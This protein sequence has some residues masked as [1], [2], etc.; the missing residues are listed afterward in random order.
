MIKTELN[1]EPQVKEFDWKKAKYP[2]IG[3]S[4]DVGIVVLFSGY[5]E[6][7]TL[8]KTNKH[9]IAVHLD[10]WGMKYFRPLKKG[11]SITLS[12]EF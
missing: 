9:D 12:N 4:K 6:G 2:I 7:T 3:I 5:E 8:N 1:I 10:Y 11:E